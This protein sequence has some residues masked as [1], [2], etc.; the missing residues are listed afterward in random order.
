M[1]TVVVVLS[2]FF[3]IVACERARETELVFNVSAVNITWGP[4]VIVHVP[5]AYQARTIAETEILL[6]LYERDYAKCGAPF[7]PL[8]HE[9]LA[10]RVFA[11]RQKMLA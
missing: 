10:D 6:Y 2:L 5:A 11:L 3:A 8:P 4:R 9:S 1:I 7:P